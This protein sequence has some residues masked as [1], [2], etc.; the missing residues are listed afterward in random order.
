MHLCSM[1]DG[2]VVLTHSLESRSIVPTGSLAKVAVS[3]DGLFYVTSGFQWTRNS[4]GD[5]LKWLNLELRLQG[6]SPLF[7]GVWYWERL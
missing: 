5:G 1:I 3:L 2:G 4:G 6:S 7:P